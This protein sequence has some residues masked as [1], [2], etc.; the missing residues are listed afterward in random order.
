MRM[1]LGCKGNMFYI[2]QASIPTPEEVQAADAFWEEGTHYVGAQQPCHVVY[3]SPH[4]KN[5]RRHAGLASAPIEYRLAAGALNELMAVYIRE[6]HKVLCDRHGVHQQT[7][8]MGSTGRAFCNS[9]FSQ[10][11]NRLLCTLGP[12][13]PFQP[14]TATKGRTLFVEHYI[15]VTGDSP[16]NWEGPSY[17]MGN[18][19]RQWRESY[20][21]QRLRRLGQKAVDNLHK[22]RSF[23]QDQG[24]EQSSV[25]SVHSA[26]AHTTAQH[27]ASQAEAP[28]HEQEGVGMGRDGV[29]AD[30]DDDDDVPLGG[31]GGEA[32]EVKQPQHGPTQQHGEEVGERVAPGSGGGAAR[33]QG[34]VDGL[35]ESDDEIM[36]ISSD[37]GGGG[38]DGDADKFEDA[39]DVLLVTS[40]EE[41]VMIVEEDVDV[42]D[43]FHDCDE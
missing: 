33:R 9:T 25:P 29:M 2:S 36:V 16:E 41:D 39:S 8:F 35:V 20:A 26:H 42:V 28:V 1:G 34:V 18:S 15:A 24:R 6:G 10:Y 5:D 30:D 31:S 37:E 17:A 3:S 22:Y 21:P 13:T 12:N 23:K 40:E 38:W 43:L 14:F 32:V 19:P 27:H 4:H 11:W 7:L